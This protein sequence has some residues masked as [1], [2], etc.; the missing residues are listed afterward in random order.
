MEELSKRLKILLANVQV[1]QEGVTK[2]FLVFFC[3][4]REVVG[5]LER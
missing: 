1:F 2:S 4:I 3:F 5:R